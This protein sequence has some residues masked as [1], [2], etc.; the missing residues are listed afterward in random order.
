MTPPPSQTFCPALPW[1]IS[2]TAIQVGEPL[3]SSR[4]HTSPSAQGS[5]GLQ[6]PPSQTSMLRP[7]PGEHRTPPSGSQSISGSAEASAMAPF[8]PASAPGSDSASWPGFASGS[9]SAPGGGLRF[10]EP[11]CDPFGEP[12][13]SIPGCVVAGSEV[14][15]VTSLPVP[16]SVRIRSGACSH[17]AARIAIKTQVSPAPPLERVVSTTARCAPHSS[18]KLCIASALPPWWQSLPQ[19][20]GGVQPSSGGERHDARGSGRVLTNIG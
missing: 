3:S 13:A 19:T 1:Q 16:E 12:V 8:S 5:A 11:A 14:V 20:T 7:P 9:D 15:A 2:A 18:A 17:P 10:C 4:L 6:A